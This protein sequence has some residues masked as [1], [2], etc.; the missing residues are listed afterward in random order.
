MDELGMNMAERLG[1]KDERKNFDDETE[2]EVRTMLEGFDIGLDNREDSISPPTLE[3]VPTLRPR[4]SPPL[5]TMDIS[6]VRYRPA[7]CLTQAE[8]TSTYGHPRLELPEMG[9][10]NNTKRHNEHPN[11]SP[12]VATV[13]NITTMVYTYKSRLLHYN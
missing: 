10:V 3:I 6:S 7:P 4:P 2:R 5:H 8:L 11:Q 1:E 12:D 9:K 13:V